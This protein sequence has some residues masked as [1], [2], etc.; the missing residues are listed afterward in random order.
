MKRAEPSNQGGAQT[1]PGDERRRSQRVMIRIPVS[2]QA[3]V[4]GQRVSIRAVTASVNDH[5][6]MLLCARSLP[7]HAQIELQN[8]HTHQKLPC[9]V[10]RAPAESPEGYLI[11]VEFN[12]PAEGFWQISFP[13]A[14]WKPPDD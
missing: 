11:A 7:A 1:M 12:A 8:E 14:N 6:A 10:T 5:G 4:S 9:R 13:P 3:V 2:V